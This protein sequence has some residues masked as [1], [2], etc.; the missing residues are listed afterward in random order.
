MKT[1]K[2]CGKEFE[3]SG[4]WQKYCSPQCRERAY[5]HE[6]KESKTLK[7]YILINSNGERFE[8][9]SM[10]A[11]VQAHPEWFPKWESAYVSLMRGGKYRGWY[12]ESREDKKREGSVL[13]SGAGAERT[14]PYCGKVF[15]SMNGHIKY[16]S[17]KC[18]R[19]SLEQAERARLE[20]KKQLKPPVMRVC[21]QCGKEFVQEGKRRKYCGEVCAEA[22]RKARTTGGVAQTKGWVTQTINKVCAYCGKEFMAARNFSKYCSGECRRKQNVMRAAARQREKREGMR[23]TNERAYRLRS[24]DGNIYEMKFMTRFIREHPE[25]FPNAQSAY[26][27]LRY[28]GKYKGWE[29]IGV[30]REKKDE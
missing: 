13:S 18:A 10:L 23:E 24:P 14:C 12:I 5:C 1:C 17:S 4:S 7:L 22:A 19:A 3:P 25:W 26:V 9:D 30:M 29:A 11:F 27:H 21:A 8:T 20:R 2:L 15:V 28:P 16:C 6:R